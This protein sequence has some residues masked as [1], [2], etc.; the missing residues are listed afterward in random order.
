M[1]SPGVGQM[2]M[3]CCQPGGHLGHSGKRMPPHPEPALPGLS[4]S[5]PC[6]P[7]GGGETPHL[8]P[9]APSPGWERLWFSP[10]SGWGPRGQSHEGQA[11]SPEPCVG[12]AWKRL[13]ARLSVC[14]SDWCQLWSPVRTKLS[15]SGES[16]T[17]NAGK[18]Q[19]W[20]LLLL[21]RRVGPGYLLCPLT[22][23]TVMRLQSILRTVERADL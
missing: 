17:R 23:K 2:Q 16:R 14:S 5:A 8:H 1:P 20:N 11:A 22:W 12:G 6:R 19:L 18:G 9:L 10:P 7:S 4:V 21:P 13:L 3:W 15:F